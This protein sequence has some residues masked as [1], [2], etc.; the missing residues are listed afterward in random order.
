M[1][2]MLTRKQDGVAL[3]IVLWGCTLAAIT[4]GALAS[5]ARVEGVQARGQYLRVRG[6]YAAEAGIELAVFRLRA[7]Q[8]AERW[9]ADGRAYR[10]RQDNADVSISISDEDGKINLNRT[11]PEQIAS[12]LLAAGIDPE[13]APKLRDAII[14]WG[15]RGKNFSD[16]LLAEGGFASLEELRR[17]PGMTPEVVDRLDP[18]LTLWST[19]SSPNLA[20]ASSI[21]VAA[22]TGAGRE[23]SEAYVATVRGMA[24]GNEL[25]PA[26]PNGLGVEASSSSVRSSGTVTITSTASENGGPAVKIQ[27][28][29]ILASTPGDPHAYR[30]IRWRESGVD[31]P[32]KSS[33]PVL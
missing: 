15:K 27:A 17:V 28:T 25:L 3:L 26:M 13:R 22:T 10:F 9:A 1:S 23:A 33:G 12:L 8:D 19:S 20:H 6:F 32:A 31:D 5:S 7:D 30:V 2:P 14:G 24:P 16:A 21:V 18:A 11:S 4:L 29:V